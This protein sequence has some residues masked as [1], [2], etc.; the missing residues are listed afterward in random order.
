MQGTLCGGRTTVVDAAKRRGTTDSDGLASEKPQ[1]RRARQRTR[2][3]GIAASTR[4][5]GNVCDE[6][7][8]SER[9]RP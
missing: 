8:S 5:P 7:E 2:M 1:G 9:D 6:R 3:R 4:P